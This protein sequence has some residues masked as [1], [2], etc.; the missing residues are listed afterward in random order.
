MAEERHADP[1]TLDYIIDLRKQLAEA[2][3]QRDNA[4]NY[5]KSLNEDRRE[6]LEALK[7]LGKEEDRNC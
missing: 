1:V 6:L 5:L 2:E 7:A 3:R 4:L